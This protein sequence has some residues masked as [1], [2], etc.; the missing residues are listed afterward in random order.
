MTLTSFVKDTVL[1][2]LNVNF[3]KTFISTLKNGRLVEIDSLYNEPLTLWAG[4]PNLNTTKNG[5][6]YFINTRGVN[7]FVEL[8]RDSLR[9]IIFE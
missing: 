7:S 9:T 8:D 1:Y 4:F 2:H 5:F 3:D 6:I